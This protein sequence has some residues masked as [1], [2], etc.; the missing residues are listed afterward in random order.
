MTMA[1]TDREVERIVGNCVANQRFEGLEPSAEDIEAVRRIARGETTAA[2]EIA[3]I[4]AKYK[5]KAR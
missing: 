3:L 2:E 1:L 5:D 4:V